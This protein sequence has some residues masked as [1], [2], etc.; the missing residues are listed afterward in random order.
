MYKI[1][2]KLINVQQNKQTVTFVHN[3]DVCIKGKTF[4]LNNSEP[5][6]GNEQNG[7]DEIFHKKVVVVHKWE[8][9]KRSA[10]KVH[11]I[12]LKTTN[13]NFQKLK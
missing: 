7:E 3:F 5:E 10:K 6:T 12:N 9:P 4:A 8:R 13:F 2:N 1:I 11:Q